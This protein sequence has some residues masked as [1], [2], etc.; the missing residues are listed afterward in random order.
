VNLGASFAIIR[1]LSRQPAPNEL[2]AG[3]LS[4]TDV[5]VGAGEGWFGRE[6]DGRSTW[7]WSRGKSDLWVLVGGTRPVTV[8]LGFRVRGLGDRLVTARLGDRTLWRGAV[9]A[10]MVSASLPELTL[11]PGLSTITFLSEAPGVAESPQADA[12][13]LTFALYD[14]ALK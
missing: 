7:V 4:G 11:P 13:A 1:A 5:W 8:G 14:L 3:V 6:S 10:E 2:A 12:R 9:G